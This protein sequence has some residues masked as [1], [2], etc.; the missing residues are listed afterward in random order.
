MHYTEVL[1]RPI[2]TE[3]ST[4]L[5]ERGKYTFEIHVQATKRE[6][7]EAVEKVF[8][9]KVLKINVLRIPGK[10]KTFGRRK[11]QRAPTKKAI[12][13]LRPGDKIQIFES[14]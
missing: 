1:R 5:Q 7:K 4:A 11:I 8:N 10:L 14:V 9:V 3:K 2:V 12:V 13:T 6:V